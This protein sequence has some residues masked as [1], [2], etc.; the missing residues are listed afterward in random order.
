MFTPVADYVTEI[1]LYYLAGGCL[2]L[3]ILFLW[4]KALLKRIFKWTIAL[5]TFTAAGIMV[6]MMLNDG[7]SPLWDEH[8][9]GQEKKEP[10]VR[11]SY[12]RDPMAGVQEPFKE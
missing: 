5:T 7:S 8:R 9:Q 4:N 1:N 12:Y 11:S 3:F 2:S 6:H 10:L